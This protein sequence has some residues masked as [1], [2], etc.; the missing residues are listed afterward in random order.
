MLDFTPITERKQSFADLAQGLTKADLQRYTNEMIDTELA[1]I[2][3]AVDVDVNFVPVDPAANDTFGKPE[4]ASLAWTLGHVVVHAAASSEEAAAISSAFARGVIQE[5]RS[6]YE[7]PWD[8][9]QTA[10]QLRQILEESRRMRLAFLDTWPA[11]PHLDLQQEH[12]YFGTTN[13]V[14][15]FLVGLYH[16]ASHIEQLR[17]IVRQAQTARTA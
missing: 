9:L 14:S 10:A 16:E 8:S 2:A 1:I 12:P 3:D 17:E 5:G 6:R 11:A 7:V 4:E 13:A 15:R